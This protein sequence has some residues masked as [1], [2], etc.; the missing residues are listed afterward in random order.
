MLSVND[1]A[2]RAKELT[3]KPQHNVHS[4]YYICTNKLMQLS[5]FV[6]IETISEARD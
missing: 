5:V 3:N 2:V 1:I 4:N 6:F